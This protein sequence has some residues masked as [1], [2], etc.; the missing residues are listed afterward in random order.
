MNFLAVVEEIKQVLKVSVTPQRP[1]TEVWCRTY[2]R[3]RLVLMVLR[4]NDT[5]G[6]IDKI[7]DLLFSTLLKRENI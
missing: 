7:V 2:A 6:K 4:A 3:D 5:A 1:K